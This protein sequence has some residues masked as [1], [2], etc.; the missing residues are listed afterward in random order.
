MAVLKA[1]LTVANLDALSAGLSVDQLGCQM[2]ENWAVRWACSMV[3]QMA[4][5]L[6]R[7]S[8]AQKVAL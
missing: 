1:M 2:A 4:G 7:R 6:E 5:W 3:A 8:A